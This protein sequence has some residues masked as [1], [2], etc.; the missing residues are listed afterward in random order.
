MN[1][2]LNEHVRQIVAEAIRQDSVLYVASAARVADFRQPWRGES[3]AVVACPER[4]RL[5]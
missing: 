3:R 5:D 2:S 4:F 1:L